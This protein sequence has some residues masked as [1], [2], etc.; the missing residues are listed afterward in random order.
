M[1]RLFLAFPLPRTHEAWLSAWMEALKKELSFARWVKPERLHLTVFFIGAWQ[2]EEL[3]RLYASLEE[4]WSRIRHP[5]TLKIWPDLGTFG[6]PRAPRILWAKTTLLQGDP[7]PWPLEVARALRL[8]RPQPF[9]PHITLAREG[10]GPLP[11]TLPPPPEPLPQPFS[12]SHLILY[13]S[14]LGPS[15]RYEALRGFPL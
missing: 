6:P 12:P 15:P 7:S 13:E 11:P 14:F 4:V 9:T 1:K 10:R 5:I 8:P 3:P 2:E